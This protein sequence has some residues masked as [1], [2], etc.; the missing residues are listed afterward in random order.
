VSSK[1]TTQ[2]AKTLIQQNA[3]NSKFAIIDVRT[4]AEYD[5][6]HLEGAINIDFNSTGFKSLIDELDRSKIYLVYC[7]TGV[8]SANAVKIMIEMGFKTVYDMSGGITQWEKDSY[9]V[10]TPTGSP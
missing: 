6:G 7:R 4:P 2:D 5:S 10:V 3:E 8:R 1:I 9:P